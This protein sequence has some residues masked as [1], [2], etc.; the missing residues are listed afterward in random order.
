MPGSMTITNVR[1][2]DLTSGIVGEPTDLHIT[3]G[4]ITR[5]APERARVINADGAVIMPGLWDAHVHMSQWATSSRWVDVSAGSSAL[6]VAAIL[7][8]KIDGVHDDVVIGFG[9]RDSTWP[10]PPTAEALDAV[11]GQRPCVLISGDV[12]SV[13]A[14]SAA[15]ARF[16]LGDCDGVLREEPA[17]ALQRRLQQVS[18]DTLDQWVADAACR[19]AELGIVGIYDFTMEWNIGHWARRFDKGFGTLCIRAATYPKWL[20]QFEEE[21]LHGGD[22]LGTDLFAVGPLKVITD[23]SLSSGTAWCHDPYGTHDHGVATVDLPELVELMGRARAA[24]LECAVHAIGDRALAQALDAYTETGARGSIEHAQLVRPED[25]TRM[26]DLGI[27]ASVQPAHLLDDRDAMDMLWADRGEHAFPL[28]S[29]RDAG[30]ELA[31]GSDA[32]VAP[33]DPWLAV[34]AAVRRSGDQRAPWHAEQKLAISEALLA[35]TRGVKSLVVGAEADIVLLDRNP[36]E[37]AETELRR[38][39]PVL[40]MVGGHITCDKL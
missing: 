10:T 22:L 5:M 38:V 29:L 34:E 17:F 33:L 37:A 24:R 8:G 36:F 32:P 2:L 26:A 14:N 31:F 39:R 20:D 40:T 4:M 7:A 30:V 15:I 6:E 35:S 23:G 3:G 1:H 21:G 28:R 9:F 12:H 11:T 16:G 18:D 13:W 25:V 19:A 27:R